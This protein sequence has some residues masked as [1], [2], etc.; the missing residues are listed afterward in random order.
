MQAVFY[1]A[2]VSIALL[3]VV[4]WRYEM[5]S[6]HASAQLRTLRRLLSGDDDELPP[7]RRS[8]A[9]DVTGVGGVR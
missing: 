2:M 6:K 1:L 5:T 9:P 7:V 8:A 3:W 4:L